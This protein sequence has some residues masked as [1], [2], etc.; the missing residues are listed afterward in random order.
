ML[1]SGWQAPAGAGPAQ[2]ADSG[3]SEDPGPAHSLS[4]RCLPAPP[5]PPVPTRSLWNSLYPRRCRCHQLS[6]VSRGPSASLPH[7]AS[8]PPGSVSRPTFRTIPP[9]AFLPPA[10]CQPCTD[11]SRLM[12]ESPLPAGWSGPEIRGL[13]VAQNPPGKARP[14]GF[15]LCVGALDTCPDSLLQ[16]S[17]TVSQ[18]PLAE[19]QGSLQPWICCTAP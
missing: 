2:S 12:S 6:F 10:G 13:L 8:L 9:R 7:P 4:P 11:A 1:P 5:L 16:N 17:P 15:M 19:A 18:S 3:T 14:A